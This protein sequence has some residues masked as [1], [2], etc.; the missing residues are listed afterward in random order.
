MGNYFTSIINK[1]QEGLKEETETD[2]LN[3]SAHKSKKSFF[4]KEKVKDKMSVI[5]NPTVKHT[6]SVIFN[7]EKE[8]VSKMTN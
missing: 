6:A 5:L 7:Y 2:R 3:L 8:F 1:K 4:I